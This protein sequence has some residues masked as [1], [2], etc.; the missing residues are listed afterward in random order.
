MHFD[1]WETCVFAELMSG[2]LHIVEV[3]GIVDNLLA[4]EFVVANF[5]VHN[6]AV[7]FVRVFKDSHDGRA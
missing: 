2:V 4:V 5:H 7:F 6:E 3:V 1:E